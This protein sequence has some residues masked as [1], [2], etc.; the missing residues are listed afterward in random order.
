VQNDELLLPLPMPARLG[1]LQWARKTSPA[2]VERPECSA[3]AEAFPFPSFQAVSKGDTGEMNCTRPDETECTYKVHEEALALYVYWDR[4]QSY[5]MEATSG[6]FS[7]F[8]VLT[9]QRRCYCCFR[10]RCYE[11]T[12]MC[13]GNADPVKEPDVNCAPLALALSAAH[14]KGRTTAQCCAQPCACVAAGGFK[15]ILT[16]TEDIRFTVQPHVVLLW[17]LFLLAM[18][19][20]SQHD[21]PAPAHPAELPQRLGHMAQ[22][23]A[24]ETCRE[25]ATSPLHACG[26]RSRWVCGTFACSS[27]ACGVAVGLIAAAANLVAAATSTTSLTQTIRQLGVFFDSLNSTAK[28]IVAEP[29]IPPRTTP[30][31]RPIYREPWVSMPYACATSTIEQMWHVHEAENDVTQYPQDHF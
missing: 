7:G 1:C 8:G 13:V 20:W 4:V 31:L 24:A 19:V 29:I 14:T 28:L 26:L 6:W 12:G 22:Y 21:V 16:M 17:L 18:Q 23:V 27:I 2:K 25:L 5:G 30:C 10:C 11:K 3:C 15:G 9:M